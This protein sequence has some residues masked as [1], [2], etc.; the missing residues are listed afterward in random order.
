MS[1]LR[2]HLSISLSMSLTLTSAVAALTSISNCSCSF[3]QIDSATG[4][5]WNFDLRGLYRD[6]GYGGDEWYRPDV[7]WTFYANI[8]GDTPY[9][10]ADGVA[11]YVSSA[12]VVQEIN[13]LPSPTSC[14]IWD[15]PFGRQIPCTKT[16]IPVSYPNS[17]K[18]SVAN[19]NNLATGGLIITY[20]AVPDSPDDSNSC[21]PDL[22]R[23][24]IPSLRY[25]TMYLKC[26]LTSNNMSKVD[27]EVGGVL[28]PNV[29][30]Y[31][32]TGLTRAACGFQYSPPTTSATPSA[33]ATM[34]SI[35]SAT[36]TA[37]STTSATSSFS[38]LS[39]SS[40]TATSTTSLSMTST[41]S[42]TSSATSSATSSSTSSSTSTSSSSSSP[43]STSTSSAAAANGLINGLYSP[44]DRDVGVGTLGFFLGF[45]ALGACIFAG[46]R[47]WLPWQWLEDDGREK[48]YR[49]GSNYVQ[50][51]TSQGRNGSMVG[52][53]TLSAAT[54]SSTGGGGYRSPQKFSTQFSQL[55]EEQVG[56]R[57]AQQS[58]GGGGGSGVRGGRGGEYGTVNQPT[59]QGRVISN[60]TQMI[61]KTIIPRSVGISVDDSV[62]GY[63]NERDN[64]TAN[65]TTTFEDNHCRDKDEQQGTEEVVIEGQGQDQTRLSAT[66]IVPNPARFV[67][68]MGM[69]GSGGGGGRGR[70]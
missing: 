38:S 4:Q 16:C 52:S 32:I 18:I 51:W 33:L 41:T 27:W 62:D 58:S 37:S 61:G 40:S 31:T 17:A 11:Q 54:A 14:P 50:E 57:F 29:C 53:A 49:E 43:T 28:E 55:E 8:C 34:S 12:A 26:D 10:C 13:S 20:D 60:Q 35:S 44:I 70:E 59:Q 6:G 3:S 68:T 19:G 15:P 69:G 56:R 24:G 67:N 46:K 65:S 1:T 63:Y 42:S 7:E 25:F 30:N 47:R 22:N 48:G 66:T 5:V 45:L 23:K 36:A 39:T 2:I 64:T 9:L 21:N